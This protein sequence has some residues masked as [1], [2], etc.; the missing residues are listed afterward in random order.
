M[1][2]AHLI[3]GVLDRV[4]ELHGYALREV[5]RVGSWSFPMTNPSIYPSLSQLEADSLV[6]S[7]AE[8][9]QGRHRRVYAITDSGRQ[10][11]RRWLADPES[12]PVGPGA[13]RDPM[14]FR[15]RM[16]DSGGLEGAREWIREG[17]R[18]Q[19]EY[20]E[21]LQGLKM[22]DPVLARVGATS[23]PP[24]KFI[25]LAAEFAIEQAR[26]RICFYERVLEQI[27]A[28]LP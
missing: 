14:L 26:L 12:L 4:P 1:P 6:T 11:L 19:G 8:I 9:T 24:G 22:L 7:R 17:I 3:L 28:D 25:N 21:Q 5:T 23:A 15:I 16:L 10:E 2:L 13:W 20:V 18:Y 27:E